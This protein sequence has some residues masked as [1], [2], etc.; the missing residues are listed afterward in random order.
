MNAPP[1]SALGVQGVVGGTPA[2]PSASGGSAVKQPTCPHC[3]SGSIETDAA[4]GD[5]VCT[6]CGAVLETSLIVS[7]IQFE[8]N[9]H[10]GSNAIGQFVS[11][12]QKGGGG[13]GLSALGGR[14]HIS[15]VGRESREIT[16]RNA[17]NKIRALGQQLALRQDRIE[18]AFNFFRMA[19]SRNLTRGRKSTHVIAACVYITCRTEGTSHML[20]DFSDILQIDVY[21]LGRTYLKLSQELCINI[22]AMD[23]CL[24][25][26]RFA[27]KLEFGDKTHEVSMTALRLVSRMKKDWIHFGRRP[28]GLCGA[29]L[30]IA[31]RLHTYNRTVGDVIKVVKVH[32]STLRK[33]LNE[34]GETPASQLTLDEFMNIDLDAMTEEQ[35]PPSY[36]AAR[37]RDR[38][39]LQQL[40][41]EDGDL[42]EQITELER[43]IERELAEKR[44]RL[45]GPYAR[46]AR[47]TS[48][49]PSNQ[50]DTLDDEER[51]AEQ[52]I[53]EQ[54]LG[55]IS[56][57][58]NPEASSDSALMPP[59]PGSYGKCRPIESPGLGLKDTIQEYLMPSPSSSTHSS[60][61]SMNSAKKEEALHGE[62]DVEEELDLDGIDEDEIDSY[63]MSEHEI[64]FKTEMW[65]KVNAEY[66]KEKAE[67]EERERKEEEEALKEGREIKKKKKTPKKPKVN[68]GGNQT[69]LEAIE[70]IVQEKKI[71]TKINY[72]VLRSLNMS[73]TPMKPGGDGEADDEEDATESAHPSTPTS[74]SL[75]TTPKSASDQHPNTKSRDSNSL[76]GQSPITTPAAISQ[77]LYSSGAD[78]P[79]KS[80]GSASRKRNADDSK[81]SLSRTKSSKKLKPE[82]SKALE[83]EPIVETGPVEPVPLPEDEEEEFHE[84]EEEEEDLEPE[85]QILSAA[86][87][88]SKHRGDD[89]QPDE[90]YGE[91]EDY[92]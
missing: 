71:S 2:T 3:G 51:D 37:K 20:I 29:A 48:P 86:E 10:G 44:A 43:I 49:T 82:K 69:A 80:S 13:L 26:M 60:Y 8:E 17:R 4:R 54:T 61:S 7:D 46:L 36:K 18:M 41:A 79:P 58:V 35:D 88:L 14:G 11:A 62:A 91:E 59:P 23:P 30:L 6:D 15:G 38:E 45:G 47:A 78:E 56:E 77:V 75:K 68:M 65:L 52:F 39:R 55:S 73:Y 34:F 16:L 24:Y 74:S 67:K 22:P 27:H 9:A 64:K 63:I 53:T 76:F 92:Y 12:D 72:E 42:D 28:S 87:L 19:L 57:I 83:P 90:Y 89:G 66:L 84:E 25:V 70:K 1:H 33:R 40:E 31:A 21:E 50:S 32:E 85:D 81:S 5:A